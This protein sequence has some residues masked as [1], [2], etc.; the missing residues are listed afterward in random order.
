MLLD[1]YTS[2]TMIPGHH[3]D[4]HDNSVRTKLLQV[5]LPSFLP[6]GLWVFQVGLAR[7]CC[8]SWHRIQFGIDTLPQ[9][10]EACSCKRHPW[11]DET[12]VC[13]GSAPPGSTLSQKLI[14]DTPE[15][16]IPWV[17]DVWSRL[18]NMPYSPLNTLRS[19]S[20]FWVCPHSWCTIQF[21]MV[22]VFTITALRSYI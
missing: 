15:M 4:H 11:N 2:P 3:S 22:C 9:P 6:L 7:V 19:L 5:F 18:I 13:Q 20:R 12:L 21:P 1:Q 14:K 8:T 17:V 16:M 10:Q